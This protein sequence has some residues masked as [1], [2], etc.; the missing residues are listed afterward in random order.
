MLGGA[1][2]FLK[3]IFHSET[4]R[5]LGVHCIG[6]GAT[7][8]IHIGQARMYKA[9]GQ[10]NEPLSVSVK[11]NSNTLLFF[12]WIFFSPLEV[13]S[14]LFSFFCY[15]LGG[16][17]GCT[18]FPHFLAIFFKFFVLKSNPCVALWLVE[19]PPTLPIILF[20]VFFSHCSDVW[21][22]WSQEYTEIWR[23]ETATKQ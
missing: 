1:H 19:R 22:P 15:F 23:S 13:F 6:E 18:V 5:L 20:F 21:D 4:L 8:I 10:L 17:G 12:A 2:G 16:G 14:L 7:E 3:L 9:L 11:K